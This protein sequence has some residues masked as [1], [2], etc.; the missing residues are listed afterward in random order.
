MTV[1]GI[2]Q[3]IG[4]V[5]IADRV[6]VQAQQRNSVGVDR[7]AR[8]AHRRVKLGKQLVIASAVYHRVAD[9]VDVAREHKA[10]IVI[11]ALYQTEVDNHLIVQT[12]RSEIL[13]KLMQI[14]K[15]CLCL[16]TLADF[17]RL[18]DDLFPSEQ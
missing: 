6:V 9:T 7:E 16:G 8:G 3:Y 18:L 2:Y 4:V 11:V 1:L 10:R 13:I 17:S 15:R 14:F 12:E 5:G